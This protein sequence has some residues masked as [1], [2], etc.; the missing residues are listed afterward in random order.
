MNIRMSDNTIWSPSRQDCLLLDISLFFVFILF[1][2]DTFSDFWYVQ[3]KNSGKV[4]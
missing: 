1:S 4:W 3:C 2:I